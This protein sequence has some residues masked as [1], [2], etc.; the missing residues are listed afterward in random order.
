MIAAS[1]S[2][3]VAAGH[4]ASESPAVTVLG[5][6]AGS[7]GGRR[8]PGPAR[9]GQADRVCSDSLTVTDRD[10]PR[11]GPGPGRPGLR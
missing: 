8:G 11:L 6:L 1:D 2:A 4:S 3:A 10:G 7:A 9:P 5:A